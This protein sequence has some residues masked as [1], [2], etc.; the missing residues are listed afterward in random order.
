MS[1]LPRHPKDRGYGFLK[2]CEY[3]ETQSGIASFTMID[4][5]ELVTIVN[6]EDWLTKPK[7]NDKIR[8]PI[9]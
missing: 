1:K 6:A 9:H 3:P 4:L 2:A 8:Q 7:Q 5:A